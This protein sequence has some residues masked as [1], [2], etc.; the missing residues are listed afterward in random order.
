MRVLE[1]LFEKTMGRDLHPF[2]ETILP[3]HLLLFSP[4]QIFSFLQHPVGQGTIKPRRIVTNDFINVGVVRQYLLRP[5]P[6]HHPQSCMRKSISE[7]FDDRGGKNDIPDMIKLNYRDRLDFFWNKVF[8]I[9]VRFGK[10]VLPL[11][12]CNMHQR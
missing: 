1:S 12:Y 10:G 4:I 9:N 3:K 6:H 8:Q 5:C 7:R 2:W 11:G